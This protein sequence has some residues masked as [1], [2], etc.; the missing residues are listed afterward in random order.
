MY[1][2]STLDRLLLENV[3]GLKILLSGVLSLGQ[4]IPL[5]D[6]SRAAPCLTP[7]ASV[8]RSVVRFCHVTFTIL[9]E[10]L[11]VHLFKDCLYVTWS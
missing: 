5:L 10:Q 11:I 8:S 7:D 4:V 1:L 3:T 6:C 2:L 9:L